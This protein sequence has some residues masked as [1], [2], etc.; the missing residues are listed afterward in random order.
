MYAR[1]CVCVYVC[2]C[3]CVCVEVD[4]VVWNQLPSPEDCILEAVL[5]VSPNRQYRGILLPTTPAQHDPG[6]KCVY[7]ALT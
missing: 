2:V 1:V 4:K 6:K 3:V 5:T 7:I